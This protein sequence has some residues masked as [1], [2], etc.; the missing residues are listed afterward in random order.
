MSAVAVV[1][2]STHYLPRHLVA[3]HGIEEVC[4]YVTLDGDQRRERDIADYADFY[5]TLRAGTS[6]PT[7]S[8]PSIGDFLAAY[9]P[10]SAA[11]RDIVSMHISGGIS[12][13]VESAR[14][15]AAQITEASRP[16][17]RGRRLAPAAGALAAAVLGRAPPRGR[18]GRS[19]PVA[20]RA[21]RRRARCR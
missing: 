15:A 17:G 13:T 1:T 8:Q 3:E 21:A 10:L 9:E 16:A 14:Q 18:R 7:T 4:L 20:A 2:D 6:M 19:M 5:A 12:G 11:G